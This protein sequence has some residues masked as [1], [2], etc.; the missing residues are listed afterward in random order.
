MQGSQDSVRG[1]CSLTAAPLAGMASDYFGRKP[2]LLISLLF[3]AVPPLALALSCEAGI[4][5]PLYT[6]AGFFDASATVAA[7]AYVAV[8]AE[9]GSASQSTVFAQLFAIPILAM[10][11]GAPLGGLA[12]QTWRETESRTYFAVV[13]ALYTLPAIYTLLVVAEPPHNGPDVARKD[14]SEADE[15]EAGLGYGGAAAGGP[16][17]PCGAEEKGGGA[18]WP[19][20]CVAFLVG[21]EGSG[22]QSLLLVYAAARFP[23][24]SVECRA[25]FL[26]AWA[27][28]SAAACLLLLPPT[29]RALGP[30]GTLRLAL[31]ANVAHCVAYAFAPAL[32]LFAAS[33]ALSAPAAFAYSVMRALAAAAAP[34]GRS[35]AVMGTMEAA[36]GGA[37]VTAPLLLAEAFRAWER[38]ARAAGGDGL[39][40]RFPGAPWLL[41]GGCV[42]LALV[43]TLAVR[44]P[45]HRPHRPDHGPSHA[46]LPPSREAPSAPRQASSPSCPAGLLASSTS[47]SWPGGGPLEPGPVEAP[48]CPLEP[49]AP[50]ATAP[51]SALPLRLEHGGPYVGPHAAAK[52]AGRG[53]GAATMDGDS[54]AWG[55][56]ACPC[57]AR[58]DPQACSCMDGRR[59]GSAADGGPS[60]PGRRWTPGPAPLPGRPAGWRAAGP[61][62]APGLVRREPDGL[63]APLL[64]T[65]M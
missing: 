18:G 52:M 21:L 55:L 64:D 40:A 38:A 43:L 16:A 17:E 37:A 1:L 36:A 4:Y 30:V 7:N 56:R 9:A 62:G 50:A 2:V 3:I 27:A 10:L 12:A 63:R 42:M 29:V 26:S 5:I 59:R 8:T 14:M 24:C 22:V 57:H 25:A 49:L 28:L 65:R 58:G 11:V 19:L 35:G 51:P 45:P 31:A 13:A 6:L 46:S 32:W 53:T 41:A 20:V 34:V 60:P 61:A 48:C 44:P 54:Q 33:L 47:C 23:A 15:G 39:A